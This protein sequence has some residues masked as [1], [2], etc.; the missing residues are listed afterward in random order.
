MPL[1]VLRGAGASGGEAEQIGGEAARARLATLALRML[2]RR[3]SLP[4][5][6]V[7]AQVIIS[8]DRTT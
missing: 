7:V 3:E 4:S 5:P 6:A 8:A 1:M 2:P